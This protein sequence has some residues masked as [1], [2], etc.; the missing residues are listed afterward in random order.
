MATKKE[1]EAVTV[2]VTAEATAA[3]SPVFTKE[4]L[5]NSKKFAK[6]KDIVSV[7]ISAGESCTTEEC[8]KRID[9]FLKGK[10]ERSVK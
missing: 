7:V 8:E 3:E 9:E 6:Y 2:E 4:Q 10:C 1:S 5:R